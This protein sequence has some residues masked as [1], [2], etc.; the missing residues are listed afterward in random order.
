[1]L[2][3]DII[4]L[5][6]SRTLQIIGW[7]LYVVVVFDIHTFNHVS[8]C[9]IESDSTLALDIIALEV[10]RKLQILG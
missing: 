8:K 4:L 2:A 1:M 10:S 7:I 9:T 3:L 6:G 5:E